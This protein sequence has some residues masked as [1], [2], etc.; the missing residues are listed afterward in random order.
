MED[1][2]TAVGV[3]DEID[4]G[5]RSAS[6]GQSVLV[7]AADSL[8]VGQKVYTVIERFSGRFGRAYEIGGIV[9]IR[10]LV[11]AGSRIYRGQV[12]YAVNPVVVGSKVLAGTPPRVPVTTKGRRNP[13]S[14]TISGGGLVPDHRVKQV[15]PKPLEV[16]GLFHAAARLAA[17]L[18]GVGH[19][20]HNHA[21]RLQ[22]T[23]QLPRHAE[24]IPRVPA[25]GSQVIV[26]RACHHQVN[27]LSRQL[28]E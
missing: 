27:A 4:S 12:T 3:L 15:Q 9:E 28:P 24:E 10:D 7:R 21:S 23:L 2:P 8:S 13:A 25:I 14:L 18:R 16:Q 6:L 17:V 1:A 26:W 22:H 11:D 19:H 20:P 5:I